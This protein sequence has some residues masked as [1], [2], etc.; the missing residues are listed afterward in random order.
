MGG[1]ASCGVHTVH[2]PDTCTTPGDET[3]GHIRPGVVEFEVDL[4]PA[5]GEKI[6]GMLTVICNVG[7]AGI[8]NKD[9]ATGD[10]RPDGYFLTFADAELGTLEFKPLEPIIGITHIGVIP[11]HELK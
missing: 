7:F 3:Y 10:P 8:V 5:D 6:T 4:Y 11:P 1:Q 2:V 9:P